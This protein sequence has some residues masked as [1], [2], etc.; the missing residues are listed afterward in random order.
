M[1]KVYLQWVWEQ[2]I[3]F[4]WRKAEW[5][6]D[7]WK[8]ERDFKQYPKDPSYFLFDRRYITS[9]RKLCLKSSRTSLPMAHKIPSQDRVEYGK[10]LPTRKMMWPTYPKA[11]LTNQKKRSLYWVHVLT[12]AVRRGSE[13]AVSESST[14][15]P[16]LFNVHIGS[17]GWK[18]KRMLSACNNKW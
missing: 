10:S 13:K 1:S 16:C 18:E 8:T 14:F 9:Q 7:P 5:V 2:Q 4:T 6:G 12:I 17:S 11:M 3:S 15:L